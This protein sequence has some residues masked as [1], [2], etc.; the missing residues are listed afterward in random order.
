LRE[1]VAGG[2]L[3]SKAGEGFYRWHGDRA[4]KDKVTTGPDDREA[5]ADRPVPRMVSEADA[6]LLEGVVEDE[7]LLDAG[8]S[9]SDRTRAGKN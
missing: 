5:V 7:D 6:C 9:V 8:V 1:L 4:K 3:G 2:K